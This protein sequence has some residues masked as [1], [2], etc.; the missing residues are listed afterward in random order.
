MFCN[1]GRGPRRLLSFFLLLCLAFAA[2]YAAVW[3][4][5]ARNQRIRMQDLQAAD[6]AV[7][8][9]MWYYRPSGEINRCTAGRVAAG[10]ALYRAGKVG[11]LIMTGRAQAA[12]MARHA[13][14]LGV[15]AED[16]LT[17]NASTDTDENLHHAARI[18]EKE[19][20]RSLVV[21]SEAYHLLRAAW[22]AS[23]RFGESTIQVYAS[24]PHCNDKR[25]PWHTLRESAA[26]IKNGLSGRYFPRI[27]R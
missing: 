5:A 21:V 15:P 25:Y 24:T 20:I 6:A 4:T 13:Q 22:L 26:I 2:L 16:I 19:N 8:L 14:A 11:K 12:D 27:S 17:E 9:G 1:A 3:R 18:A 7:V 10:V 23:T